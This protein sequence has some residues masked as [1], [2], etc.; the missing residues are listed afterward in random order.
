MT[1]GRC[2]GR[3]QMAA[4]WAFS[5]L[6]GFVSV[7]EPVAKVLLDS[8]MVSCRGD[9]SLKRSSHAVEVQNDFLLST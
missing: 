9:S 4:A 3:G 1:G 8:A 7:R 2:T 5:S 6:G